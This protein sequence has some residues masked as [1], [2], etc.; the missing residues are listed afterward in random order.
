MTKTNEVKMK[1]KLVQ[2]KEELMGEIAKRASDGQADKVMAL[3]V[4]LNLL[5]EIIKTQKKVDDMF[6]Q[7]QNG[8]TN[9]TEWKNSIPLKM[10]LNISQSTRKSAI[11]KGHERRLEFVHQLQKKSI[12]LKPHKGKTIFTNAKGERIGIAYASEAN[13]DRWFLGLPERGFDHAVLIC[14]ARSGMISTVILPRA[15]FQKYGSYLSRSGGQLKFNI[16]LRHSNY[17]IIV[18]D[19]GEINL[20]DLDYNETELLG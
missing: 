6:D 18:P 8:E 13:S 11:A 2:A 9:T 1:D 14:E 16:L 12:L 5:E 19:Q 15:F 17:F 7:W 4:R 3:S 20:K 10:D